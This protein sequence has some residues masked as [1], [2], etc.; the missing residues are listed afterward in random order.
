MQWKRKISYFFGIVFILLL[1]IPLQFTHVQQYLSIP[2]NVTLFA[3]DQS[4]SIPPLNNTVISDQANAEYGQFN[5]SESGKNELIYKY[6]NIPIKKVAVA[7]FDN[8]K[9][10]PGGQSIGVQLHTLGVL[11]VGHHL[12]NNIDQINSPGEDVNI[13][14]GDIIIEMNGEKV[15]QLD[16]LK[17]IVQ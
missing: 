14:V 1:I 13:K 7:V 6:N 4:I 12:V 15:K 3:H 17:Q 2:S 16:D 8:H 5:S 9:I 11:V 10:V